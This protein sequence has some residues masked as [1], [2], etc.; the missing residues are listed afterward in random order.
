MANPTP[1]RLFLDRDA[2]KNRHGEYVPFG[3]SAAID[4]V[5]VQSKLD[6]GEWVEVTS[7]NPKASGRKTQSATPA[8]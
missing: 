2:V 5:T 4:D 1:K 8:E 6:S 3:L 7:T